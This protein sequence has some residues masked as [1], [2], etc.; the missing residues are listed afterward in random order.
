MTED[1][2]VYKKI[3]KSDFKTKF[4]HIYYNLDKK[5]AEITICEEK[6]E[7]V[8]ILDEERFVTD[9]TII[10]NLVRKER[11]N[12]EDRIENKRSILKREMPRFAEFSGASK[13]EFESRALIRDM[14]DRYQLIQLL[15]MLSMM[16]V[17]LI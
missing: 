13:N 8:V 1:L 14:L 9:K 6:K 15:D 10:K 3:N 2:K 4:E 16:V 5:V 12:L 7:D 17:D 11:N